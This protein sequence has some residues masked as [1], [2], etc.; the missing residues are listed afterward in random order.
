VL[1]YRSA[2]ELRGDLLEVL[3][4]PHRM[5]GDDRGE[6]DE[7]E[8]GRE[9]RRSGPARAWRG[10]DDACKQAVRRSG[11]GTEKRD[12]KGSALALALRDG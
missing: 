8:E 12:E 11:D 9:R 5:N 10:G 1:L 4:A 2:G 6:T 7:D 3:V